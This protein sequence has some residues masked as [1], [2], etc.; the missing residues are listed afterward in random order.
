MKFM[1]LTK[2]KI[3]AAGLAFGVAAGMGGVAFAYLSATG[4][5]TGSA[6]VTGPQDV[7]FN[8]TTT[9]FTLTATTKVA[10]N[11]SNPN[12]FMV[13]LSG[14]ASIT[15]VTQTSASGTCKAS[16]SQ[17]AT[18]KTSGAVTVTAASTALGKLA[19]GARGAAAITQEPT[20]KLLT[21]ATTTQSA[22]VFT[23]TVSAS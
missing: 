8:V 7:Q 23:V 19:V 1:H 15:A 21:T 6:T 20:L 5:G 9:S 10:Y 3:V 16:V 2:K 14:V 22:C 17:G 4:S 11:Y 13:D 12:G 18:L